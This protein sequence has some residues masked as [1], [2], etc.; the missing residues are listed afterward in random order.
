[1]GPNNNKRVFVRITEPKTDEEIKMK[2]TQSSLAEL[3]IIKQITE[4]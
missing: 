1:M 3:V 4:S 2:S